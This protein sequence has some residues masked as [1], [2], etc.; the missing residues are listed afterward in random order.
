MRSL[1]IASVI[2]SNKISSEN[3]ITMALDIDV[4]DPSTLSVVQRISLVNYQTDLTIN[5]V[6]YN[7]ASFDI[8]LKES[9]TEVQN[10]QLTVQDQAGILMPYMKTY[11]GGVYSR[12]LTSIVSVTPD[13]TT[14]VIDFS[15]LFEVVSSNANDFVVTFEIGAENP[16]VKVFPQRK[17]M[18]DRCPFRFKSVE[19]GYSGA[20]TSCDLSL[21]GDNGC[22][23]KNNQARFGGFPSI[24]VQQV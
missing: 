20:A 4:V 12:V 6:V 10:V 17:Q 22:R 19:C 2:E 9:A 1:S 14:A 13:N 23:V 24:T 21:T 7:K 18:R 16:L 3:A 8:Q 15:E 11:K 5:G